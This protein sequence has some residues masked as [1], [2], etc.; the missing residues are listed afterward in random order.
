MSGDIGSGSWTAALELLG[1]V[2]VVLAFLFLLFMGN[3]VVSSV[4]FQGAD[5]HVD[6][7]TQVGRPFDQKTIDDDVRRLW[8]LGR[9]DDI[10]VETRQE[11]DGTGVIFDL[12]PAT[13]P[14]LR[15][16]QVEPSSIGLKVHVPAGTLI[17]ERAAHQIA[18]EARRQLIAQGYQDAQVAHTILP[19]TDHLADLKLTVDT[20]NSQKLKRTSFFGDTVF[21]DKELRRRLKALQPRQ[22]F[23]FWHLAPAYSGDAAKADAAR[24]ESFYIS[25]GYYDA[26][27]RPSSEDTRV[28]FSI[29]AGSRYEGPT[30]D[31]AG[32][33]AERRAAERR[34][35]LE[36]SA[37]VNV[38]TSVNR[39]EFETATESG[40]AYLVGR[41]NFVGNHHYS[42]K[43]IRTYFVLAEAAPFDEYLL[44][45]S[46]ARLN[47]AGWFDP[48]TES[49]IAI[50]PHP[51]IGRADVTIRLTERKRGKWSFSGPVG[52][53]RMGGPLE[54]SL[55]LRLV[56]YTPSISLVALARPI[57]PTIPVKP[58]IYLAGFQRSG[59]GWL[60]G[61][62]VAPQL[63]WQFAAMTY[64]TAKL[65][66]RLTPVLSGDQGLIPDL[67]VTVETP[68]GEKPLICQAPQPRY[69]TARKVAL[70]GLQVAGSF[71]LL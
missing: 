29:D 12:K 26:T 11:L 7:K 8:S 51:A 50:F 64:A 17:D 31:C 34:G 30:I 40:P 66:Q 53:I 60:S 69:W 18:S 10:R 58:L 27:V 71:P 1:S 68:G 59:T 54:A 3:D 67:P 14:R 9:F 15:E 5:P 35:V 62:S 4:D 61:I 6:L 20:G 41:I 21:D 2:S 22:V 28:N 52:T 16:V 13:G 36:F 25:R 42:A 37:R 46:L 48:V 65:R 57:V 39:A 32:L 43:S 47:R 38:T 33:F 63:G 19:A 45:K 70:F 56:N 24:L 44:R 49:D 55:S 23:F